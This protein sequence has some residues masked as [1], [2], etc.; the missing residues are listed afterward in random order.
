MT[1][2]T[3][4]ID[5]GTSNTAAAHTSP[6]RD[7]VETVNLA[8]DRKTIPSAVY[9]EDSGDILTGDVALN[10]GQSD[11]S[12]YVP[13]PKRI[14][15]Q[16]SFRIKGR[17][18]DAS[19]PVAAVLQTV[20]ERATRQ[21]AGEAPSKLV[22]THPE[23]WS[24][25]EIGVLLNAAQ[26]AGVPLS[27]I[28][29]ISEPKAAAH[30]YAQHTKTDELAAGDKI[31]VFDFGGGT[32]D[33][34]VLE[35]FKSTEK[36]IQFDV[37][38]AN[39][40]PTLGGKTFDAMIRE[41]V[42]Q[43]LED[44]DPDLHD[45]MR[46]ASLTERHA[47]EEHI[48]KAKEILSEAS[49]A[50]ILVSGGGSHAKVQITRVEFEAMIAAA[51]DE[52]VELTESTVAES[53]IHEPAELKALYLTGGS[54]RIPVLQDALKEVGPVAVIDDPKMVTA[55]G[56]LAGT[57]SSQEAEAAV[58][59]VPSA[60]ALDGD[61]AVQGSVAKQ[62]P[63]TDVTAPAR[64]RTGALAAAGVV[65]ALVV[66]GSFWGI[67]QRDSAPEI[68]EHLVT[69]DET[70][71]KNVNID[72]VATVRELLPSEIERQLT[73]CKASGSSLAGA[74]IVRCDLA[75]D[76]PD[77][78]YFDDLEGTWDFASLSF[79]MNTNEA[80]SK[81][82]SIRDNFPRNDVKQMAGPIRDDADNRIA[83]ASISRNSDQVEMEF[84]ATDMPLT[85]SSYDFRTPDAALQWVK[86]KGLIAE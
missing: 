72:S 24:D 43:Q 14:I 57:A 73:E 77:M 81:R 79:T 44:I 45:Y 52:A 13:S 27:R 48:R 53:G 74:L 76:S 5:F 85:V 10:A 84:A 11:P 42:F 56:A 12:G 75:Q 21:H 16:G 78:K 38:A 39:G 82:A 70:G 37:V 49:S 19:A 4:A 36:A 18:M 33:V 51:L 65:A 47:M 30:Y 3:L 40:D 32:L 62:L 29:T 23:A 50:S 63:Q 7:S 22:L 66:G 59:Q 34:A 31:A 2:W 46:R 69:T 9:V 6:L 15:P 55:L 86:D 26:E 17:D 54:T 28:E 60:G 25:K 8:H 80:R 64:R 35:A 68:P 71:E 41:W 61:L 58:Q 67:T 83:A 20:I 1:D